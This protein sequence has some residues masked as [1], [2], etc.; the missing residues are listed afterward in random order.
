MGLLSKAA[1]RTARPGRGPDNGNSVG[2]PPEY[3]LVCILPGELQNEIIKYS[4][5]FTSIHG[6]VLACPRNYDEEKERETFCGQV[7]RIVAALGS[8]VSLSSRHILVLFS[9]TIYLELLA[10]R[11]SRSLETEVPVVFQA[12]NAKAVVEYIRPFL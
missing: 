11:L 3:A 7:S 10:H 1:A 6:I 4:N 9:N 5:T 12:D 8:A 2:V